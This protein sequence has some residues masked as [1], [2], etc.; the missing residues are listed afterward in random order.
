KV[1]LVYTIDKGKKHYVADISFRGNHHI[2]SSDLK[3][4]AAVRQK[5]T[6]MLMFSHGKFSQKLLRESV[7]GI[8]GL[9]KEHGFEDVKVTPDVVDREPKLCI[10]C[11][12]AEG[13][14]TVVRSLKVEGNK[15]IS[16][17]QLRPG[18][19]FELEEGKPF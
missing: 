14:R 15:S 4:M 12:V 7:K 16:L 18:K 2:D 5:T 8:E 19:G 17:N 3:A 10:A 1:L 9:Y 6:W 11:N 13:D